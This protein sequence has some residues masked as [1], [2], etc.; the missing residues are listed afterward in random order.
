M[1]DIAA[2]NASS[3]RR[4]KY[5]CRLDWHLPPHLGDR[6][7][8]QQP[9]RPGHGHERPQAPLS[10]PRRVAQS[11]AAHRKKL[12]EFAS[13]TSRRWTGP[14]QG[15]TLASWLTLFSFLIVVQ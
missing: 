9:P 7:E 13:A 10:R 5:Y 1:H 14:G 4:L 2:L 8:W 12:N 6:R 3:P 15:T 11:A